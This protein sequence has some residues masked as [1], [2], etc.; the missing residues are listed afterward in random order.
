VQAYVADSSNY[1]LCYD[2]KSLTVSNIPARV[3][4]NNVANFK[5]YLTNA[6]ASAASS[7]SETTND[8]YMLFVGG[9]SKAHHFT[10]MQD[11]W[12]LPKA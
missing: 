8:F 6:S 2:S 5:T 4:L 7:A 9:N 11:S 3:S 1:N 10:I 12:I